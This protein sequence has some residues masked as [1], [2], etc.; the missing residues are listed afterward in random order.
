[1]KRY[2]HGL[3]LRALSATAVAGIAVFCLLLVL[4][5]RVS[6]EALALREAPLSGAERQAVRTNIP[7]L[8]EENEQFLR[9][10]VGVA[11]S[12]EV[13]IEVRKE[14][15]VQL[16][17]VGDEAAL[18]RMARALV[19]W[20]EEGWNG[21][22]EMA[23]QS[24]LRMPLYQRL[25]VTDLPVAEL[26]ELAIPIHPGGMA[27][28]GPWTAD[29]QEDA[30]SLSDWERRLRE[31]QRELVQYARGLA[32]RTLM[33]RLMAEQPLSGGA[34]PALFD[35]PA[36][37]ERNAELRRWLAGI[38]A[39]PQ[40]D[41]W[42]RGL[43][44]RALL[45]VQGDDTVRDTLKDLGGWLRDGDAE[46]SRSGRDFQKDARGL[47]VDRLLLTDTPVR[48]AVKL[49]KR[50]GGPFLDSTLGTAALRHERGRTPWSQ[51]QAARIQQRARELSSLLEG[52]GT[53]Q[54]LQ[55]DDPPAGSP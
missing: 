18:V 51:E 52:P 1:M 14:A 9:W 48:E 3:L 27:G 42:M 33:Q 47:M 53:A 45:S 20:M 44:F 4:R 2:A 22:E 24:A 34:G 40:E 37:A 23:L 41:L 11:C 8:A 54:D 32:E 13:E 6:L 38:A 15:A 19:P 21:Q 28:P 25:L 35:L 31:R 5:Q 26:H 16:L 39:S 7:R 12:D 10:L 50:H 17:E 29:R 43:A 55:A 46:R 36:L 30:P 49:A